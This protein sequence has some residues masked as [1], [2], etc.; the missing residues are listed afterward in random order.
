MTHTLKI[1]DKIDTPEKFNDLPVGATMTD[2]DGWVHTKVRDHV[3]GRGDSTSYVTPEGETGMFGCPWAWGG[4]SVLTS[5][6][7]DDGLDADNLTGMDLGDGADD[8]AV[9]VAALR[10]ENARL[11]EQVARLTALR[12]YVQDELL[13]DDQIAA[14]AGFTH[15]Y[16]AGALR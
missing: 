16:K 4:G 12:K 3:V 11:T 9:E 8:L 5:L 2:V 7:G 13:T 15:G 14:C 1:G 6:P 10:D